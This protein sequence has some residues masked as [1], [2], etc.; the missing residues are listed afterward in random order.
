[1]KKTLAIILSIV[2]LIGVMPF[3]SFAAE[4]AYDRAAVAANDKEYI[5]DMTAEQMASLILDWVDREIAKYSAEIEDDIVAGVIAN[6]GFEEL[7]AF[8]GKDALG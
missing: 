6:G 3:A 5:A 4:P 1:M 7:E 8:L 2:M